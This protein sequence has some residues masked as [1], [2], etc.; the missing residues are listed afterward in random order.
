[1]C[2]TIDLRVGKVKSREKIKKAGRV[3]V[4]LRKEKEKWGRKI[5]SGEGTKKKW[6][7]KKKKKQ[8]S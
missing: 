5:K 2:S 7:I 3:K 1:M 6:R 8:I 4:A